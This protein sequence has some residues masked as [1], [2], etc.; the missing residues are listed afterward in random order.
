MEPTKKPMTKTLTLA[1]CILN[2][3]VSSKKDPSSPDLNLKGGTL[4]NITG[5]YSWKS[6]MS[7]LLNCSLNTVNDLASTAH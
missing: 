6:M 4:I 2:A 1:L 3:E 5:K 7:L